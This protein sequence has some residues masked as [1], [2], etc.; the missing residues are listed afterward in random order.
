WYGGTREGARDVAIY[1]ATR[2]AGEGHPWSE[3][4]A[5]VTR[6]NALNETWRY[7]KKIGNAVMFGDGSS[8]MFLLYVSI[9][10]GGWSGSSL[11]AKQ[12]LDGGKTWSASQR[13]GLSPFYNVSEL[14]KNG[15][16][17]LEDGGW[18]VPIYQE[19]VGKFPEVLWLNPTEGGV[20]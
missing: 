9:G 11:N 19:L 3:P 2:E 17:P 7:V 4:R 13:L 10:V 8:R 12:S 18:A 5:L 6:E 15:P 20:K 14:V 1:W 16:T